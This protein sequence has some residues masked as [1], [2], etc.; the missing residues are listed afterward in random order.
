MSR[1]TLIFFFAALLAACGTESP[2]QIALAQERLACANVG[3]DPDSAAFG[4]C[5]GDL[6]Q[7]LLER[8]R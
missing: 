2:A 8:P 5:V 6:D 3:I 7:S 4:Q 1:I